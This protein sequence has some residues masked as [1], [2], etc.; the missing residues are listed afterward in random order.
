MLRSVAAA[1]L[2]VAALLRVSAA[3]AQ[4]AEDQATARALFDEARELMRTGHYDD[5]CP[6]LEAASKLY[7]GS[8]VLL[9]LGDCYEH[10]GRVASAWTEF[11]EASSSAARTGRSADQTEAERR[12]AAIESK[13]SRVAIRVKSDA[14]G[15]V[16]KRDG[17]ALEPAVWGDA[18]PVDPGKHV[19]TAEAPGRRPWSIE[20]DVEELGKTVTVEVPELDVAP[21]SAAEGASPAPA[22]SVAGAE[23]PPPAEPPSYWTTRRVVGASLAGAGTVATGIGVVLGLVA[24]SQYDTADNEVGTKRATDSSSAYSLGNVATVVGIAGAV[25][26]AGGL[27]LWLT[28]PSARVQVGASADAVVLRGSF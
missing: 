15:L 12:K 21:A 4:T 14:A 10:V 20:V 6:K 5:A 28:A 24:K 19:V 25:V 27:V 23:Q 7:P 11:A 16:V 22:G 3:G 17:T 13:L 1:S 26:G 9:N 18:V 8:G 2:V